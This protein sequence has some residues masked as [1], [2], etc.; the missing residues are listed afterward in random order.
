MKTV[1]TIVLLTLVAVAVVFTIG[2]YAWLGGEGLSARKK[3]SDL[4][5]SVANRM[6]SVSIPSA[7]KNAKNPLPSTPGSIAEGRKHFVDQCAICHA[8][9][10]SGET[11][12]SQ[13]LSPPVPDLRAD[14]I[15]KLT[16]G[17]L[18]YIVKNGVRFT[19]MPAW[20]IDDEHNWHL[21]VFMRALPSLA[22]VQGASGDAKK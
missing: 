3:P 10:G 15:Q 9:N 22:P 14:H 6:L 12:I 1:T 13:G 11:K 16:D 4:E 7:A 20:D 18:F 17:E 8:E 19:G 5:Y 2:V 21:V